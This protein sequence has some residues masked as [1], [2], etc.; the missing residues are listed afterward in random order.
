MLQITLY[1]YDRQL[2]SG[3]WGVDFEDGDPNHSYTKR[4]DES[5]TL[6]MVIDILEYMREV[7]DAK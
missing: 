2:P 4:Y 3:D 5:D 1:D 7:K 6:R